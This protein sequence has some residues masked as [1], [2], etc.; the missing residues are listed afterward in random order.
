VG[1]PSPTTLALEP[2]HVY[3]IGIILVIGALVGGRAFYLLEHGELD[4][5]GAWLATT[6]FTFYGGF[7]AAALGIVYYIRRRRLPSIPHQRLI[8]AGVGVLPGRKNAGCEDLIPD[9]ERTP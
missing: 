4:D 8:R 3:A 9:Q 1:S 2:D 7:I 6:G 5:P